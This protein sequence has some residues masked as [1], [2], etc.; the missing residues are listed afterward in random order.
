MIT[1][2]VLDFNKIREE[3]QKRLAREQPQAWDVVYNDCE[4]RERLSDEQFHNPMEKRYSGDLYFCSKCSNGD[5]SGTGDEGFCTRS[6]LH[7]I[8][9]ATPLFSYYSRQV[10]EQQPQPQPQ[11][12]GLLV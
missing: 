4:H 5:R 12:Q 10:K 8:K 2:M 9:D 1:L 6:V 11:E 7:T 3:K